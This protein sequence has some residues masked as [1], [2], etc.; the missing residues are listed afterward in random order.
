VPA[1]LMTAAEHFKRAADG[2]WQYRLAEAGGKVTLS[3]GAVLGV[4]AAY[5]GAFEVEGE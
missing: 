4:D 2:T 3:N 1:K 5:A